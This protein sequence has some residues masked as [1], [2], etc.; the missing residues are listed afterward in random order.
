MYF[1]RPP[2]LNSHPRL[3]AS[4]NPAAES[5]RHGN[6]AYTG[7]NSRLLYKVDVDLPEGN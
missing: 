6:C 4:P 3:H 1:I 2:P 5:K 7:E